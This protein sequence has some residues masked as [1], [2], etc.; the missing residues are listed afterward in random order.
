MKGVDAI[1]LRLDDVSLGFGGVLALDA[2]GCEVKRSEIFGIIG[3]NGAGKTSVLNCING[4]YHPQKG[5]IWFEGHMIH[6]SRP[7]KVA[8]QGISR[9]FQ[10][11][12][13]YTGLSVIDNL[14][15][16]RSFF[17]KSTWLEGGIYFGR[18]QREEERNREAVQ[19]VVEFLELEDWMHSMVGVLPYGIRKRVDVGRAMVQE[20]RLLLLDEPMAGM[21]ADE[22]DD[23]TRLIVDVNR[24]RKTTIVLIEHD[25]GVV[26]DITDRIMVL[27][28]GQKIAE[29]TPHEIQ[30]NP[31]VVAAYLGSHVAL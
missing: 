11:I 1:Q 23:L 17:F 4:F 30:T 26:M 16:A 31:D 28:F 10:D 19:E 22:K 3:P 12:K 14:M 29:G 21:N 25:M 2:V 15:A 20:P 7:D 8:R 5:K 18:G 9:T 27:D 24:R 6:G 13:L